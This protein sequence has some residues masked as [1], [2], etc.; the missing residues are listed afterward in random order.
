[1]KKTIIFAMIFI[2]VISCLF[3]P[4]C[5]KATYTSYYL[6]RGVDYD[7]L[8]I[9]AE[10]IDSNCI[11]VVFS[12]D[13]YTKNGIVVA[14]IVL[15]SNQSVIGTCKINL[16]RGKTKETFVTASTLVNLSYYNYDEVL[17]FVD[18]VEAYL[19]VKDK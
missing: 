6:A 3:L 5:S 17:V 19:L 8:S 13:I 10:Y 1:M 7:N 18:S 11:G 2:L 15:V 12:A 14:N 9:S 16:S 4:G